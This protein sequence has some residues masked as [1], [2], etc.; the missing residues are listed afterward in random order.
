M[1]KNSYTI[2]EI[3]QKTNNFIVYFLL[4]LFSVSIILP[5]LWVFITSLKTNDELFLS[6]WG[7]PSKF[8]YQNYVKAFVTAS[9]G[10]GFRNSL[11]V[12]V[13][14]VVLIV[15]VS[16]LASFIIARHPSKVTNIILMLFLAGLMIPAHSLIVPLFIQ[17]KRINLVNNL[18]GLVLVNIAFSLPTSIYIITNYMKSIPH[19][20]E[21]AAI[22]D[23]CDIFGV[24]RSIIFPLS[25]PIIVSISV[26]QF[27]FVWN[28]YLFSV[29]LIAKNALKP[30]PLLLTSFQGQYNTNYTLMFAATFMAIL[31]VILFYIFLQKFIIEGMALGAVKG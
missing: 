26:V 5:L 28:E 16:T 7:L 22:I 24:F 31:P 13:T 14:A 3:K 18:W 1:T 23:G 8:L 10:V 6:P 29:M 20:L 17:L 30:L 4:S 9:M 12:T 19:E 2:S 21:E 11:F 27:I 25:I 15:L